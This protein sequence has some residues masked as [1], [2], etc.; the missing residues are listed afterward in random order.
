MRSIYGV[1]GPS[2]CVLSLIAG[3]DHNGTASGSATELS[4]YLD[5]SVQVAHRDLSTNTKTETFEMRDYIYFFL[6]G[7]GG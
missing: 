2:L 1:G 7:A 3:V 4:L 5:R 6:S